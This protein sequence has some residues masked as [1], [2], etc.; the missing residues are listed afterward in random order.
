MH[1]ADY[2]RVWRRTGRRGGMRQICFMY[3]Q[4]EPGMESASMDAKL[5]AEL[6]VALF[7]FFLPLFDTHSRRL[8]HAG[9]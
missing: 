2:V 6:H 5:L 3:C 1:G 7:D 8:D 9:I 4:L